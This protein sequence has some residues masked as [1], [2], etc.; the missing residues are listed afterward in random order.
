MIQ[1]CDVFSPP[2]LSVDC[3]RFNFQKRS[4]PG[5]ANPTVEDCL[6]ECLNNGE[7]LVVPS[8]QE[9]YDCIFNMTG[10][11][12]FTDPVLVAINVTLDNLVDLYTGLP[13]SNF[14]PGCVANEQGRTFFFFAA[15]GNRSC[16]YLHNQVYVVAP[17]EVV[18]PSPSLSCLCG[19]GEQSDC[20]SK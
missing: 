6:Q 18:Y 3:A 9:E 16:V 5:I 17:C 12:H 2:V 20:A 10:I 13:V 19:L 8:T 14:A 11:S 1:H 15:T 4:P 7:E